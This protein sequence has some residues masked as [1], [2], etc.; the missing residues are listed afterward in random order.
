MKLGMRHEALRLCSGQALGNSKKVQVFG[1]ALCI[2][3]LT[4]CVSAEAQQQAKIPRIGFVSSS[5][6]PN[7]PGPNVDAFRQGLRELGYIDG[8]NILVEY[9]YRSYKGK[10]DSIPSLVAELTQ[11]KVDVL[12]SSISTVIRAAK[13]ATQTTPIVMVISDD[14]VAIGLVK[15][16]AHPGGNI[17]GLTRLTRELSGKRLELFKEAVPGILRVGILWHV[18]APPPGLE[19]AF[20]EYEAAARALKIPLQSL[21]VRNPNPD[22][23][24]AF[25]APANRQVNG[26]VAITNSLI[27]VHQKTIADVAKK[28][29]LSSMFE[30]SVYVGSG[31]LMSYSASDADQYRRAAI[32]VDKI[33]KGAKP[34]DLPVEQPT[35]FEF[36]INLKTAKQIGL[37]IPPNVLARA[38][39][40]I[41]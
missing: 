9:R 17:T 40:V 25:Q 4:L 31:G 37:T 14:P 29:R 38:D 3:L 5:G 20:R 8:K 30:G 10:Q 35:K 24:R 28:N 16:L 36:V 27:T 32:Y 6:D 2:L 12:V 1:F 11:L 13:Q 21:E 39:K 41:R 23:A 19:G 15:S 34:A 7:D 22:F 33:L 18:N 26:F